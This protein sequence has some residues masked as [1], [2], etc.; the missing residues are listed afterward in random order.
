MPRVHSSRPRSTPAEPIVSSIPVT[1]SVIVSS[2]APVG[3]ASPSVARAGSRSTHHPSSAPPSP[4]RRRAGRG[5]PR[6]AGSPRTPAGWPRPGESPAADRAPDRP[7]STP[8]RPGSPEASAPPAVAVPPGSGHGG[9]RRAL[10]RS[11]VRARRG[12]RREVFSQGYDCPPALL[13]SPPH[14]GHDL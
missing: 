6:T 1:G 2:S 12:G 13:A 3:L 9:W 4:R 7:A 10:V 5:P 11:G 14:F 8:P